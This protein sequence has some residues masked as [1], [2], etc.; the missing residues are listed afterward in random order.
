M[1]VEY[2]IELAG[3]FGFRFCF[4]FCLLCCADGYSPSLYRLNF[5]VELVF[6]CWAGENWRLCVDYPLLYM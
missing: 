4:G 1:E 5:C 3:R 2:G 6:D